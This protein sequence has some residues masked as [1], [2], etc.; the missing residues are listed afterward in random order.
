MSLP[1]LDG[2]I[3]DLR[4]GVRSLW[5]N[6]GVTAAAVSTL[7]ICIGGNT[8][9]FGLVNAALLRPLAYTEPGR[10]VRLPP[11]TNEQAGLWGSSTEVLSALTVYGP[12]EFTLAGYGESIKLTGMEVSTDFFSVL[13]TPPLLGRFPA[14]GETGVVV[15][16]HRSWTRFL[17]GDSRVVGRFVRLD[18]AQYEIA[19][20]MPDRFT[21][22]NRDT[23]FWVPLRSSSLRDGRRVSMSAVGRL[24]DGVSV[25]QAAAEME[26]LGRTLGLAEGGRTTLVTLREEATAA[27]R[28][29]LW[30]LQGAGLLLLSI[31]CINV[32]GLLLAR[33]TDRQSEFALRA[34]MG[35]GKIRLARQIVTES[36]V[37]AAGGALGGCL[38]GFLVLGL[39]APLARDVVPDLGVVDASLPV[40]TYSLGL[41]VVCGLLAGVAPA[42]TVSERELP[43][44]LAMGG[45]AG[46]TDRRATR[47]HTGLVVAE[48]ALALVLLVAAGL[49][50][51][52]FRTL[53]AVDPGYEPE[54]V[55]TFR[56]ELPETRYPLVEQRRSFHRELLGRVAD[57]DG[58]RGAGVT[59]SLPFEF[60]MTMTPFS[61]D[62]VRHLLTPDGGMPHPFKVVSPG[63][64]ESMGIPV[65]A[66]RGLSGGDGPGGPYVVAVS[67]TFARDRFGN[68]NPVDREMEFMGRVWRVVGVVHDVRHV[69]LD[70]EPWSEVYL[71]YRQLPAG[72]RGPW[73]SSMTFVVKQDGSR[74]LVPAIRALLWEMDPLV[75]ADRVAT[76][77]DLVFDSV[78][79]P[80]LRG[81][82]AGAF[83]VAALLLASVG[84]AGML[85]YS[86]ARRTREIGIRVALG[87]GRRRVVG[88]VMRKAVGLTTAGA[89][90][91]LV[92][93]VAVTRYLES[94]LFGVSPL[95]GGVVAASL[96]VL[97]GVA[98]VTCSFPARR[99]AGTN[100]VA[101]LRR[102]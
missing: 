68:E 63:Y 64:L 65:V 44:W 13:R 96:L 98:L 45:S 22:P 85:A 90:L 72:I 75:V 28:P 34:A 23:D 99:A 26:V 78:A 30:A 57:L 48:T 39:V 81:I 80:R 97:N 93:A 40:L 19:G 69:G 33:A 67:E 73:L 1:S 56:V 84:M 6:P 21:F 11:L 24:R 91:G 8:A 14:A 60:A 71:S 41:S 5:R 12:T 38:L 51:T 87:A 102:E 27:I 20:V 58:V 92:G 29:A 62:G 82:V 54:G 50:V 89:A 77:D 61:I 55:L 2:L 76:M 53:A 70:Q 49:L 9:I 25:E 37:M 18:D 35:A 79:G 42:I 46:T 16:S 15:M 59:N 86:V 3:I 47:T 83:A 43:R 36:V 32:A 31:A 95:D 101:A 74:A 94:L 66:G 52:S 100:V 7:A 10:I 4:L 17:G 88:L